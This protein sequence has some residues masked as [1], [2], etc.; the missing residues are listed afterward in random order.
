MVNR[1]SLEYHLVDV[2]VVMRA[3]KG[4]DES[5]WKRN[6][7]NLAE[8]WGDNFNWLEVI[9]VETCAGPLADPWIGCRRR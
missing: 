4:P 6:Y 2:K 9:E 7:K 3:W 1:L 8:D 5:L